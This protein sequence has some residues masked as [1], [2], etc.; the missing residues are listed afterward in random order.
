V[1]P[2][3]RIL[4]RQSLLGQAGQP[5]TS[6][7]KGMFVDD[8]AE[9]DDSMW[10]LAQ[11]ELDM[12]DRRLD[13]GELTKREAIHQ[14]TGIV[15]ARRGDSRGAAVDSLLDEAERQHRDLHDVARQ[16]IDSLALLDRERRDDVM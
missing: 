5:L 10:A 6:V 9:F 15:M 14:A 2:G 16:I 8:A 1:G 12:G 13:L 4:N 11:I 7:D 3:A